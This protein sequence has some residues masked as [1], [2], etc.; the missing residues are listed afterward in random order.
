MSTNGNPG[1]TPLALAKKAVSGGYIGD[2]NGT[3]DDSLFLP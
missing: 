2:N 1:A 3:E